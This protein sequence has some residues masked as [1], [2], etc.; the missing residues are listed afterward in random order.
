MSATCVILAF[1]LRTLEHGKA[2]RGSFDFTIAV[3]SPCLADLLLCQRV[4]GVNLRSRLVSNAA[5]GHRQ[6]G[7]FP[8]GTA[9][10]L[11]GRHVP[12]KPDV[13]AAPS[14]TL[15][16][17]AGMCIVGSRNRVDGGPDIAGLAGG[18]HPLFPAGRQ[19]VGGDS[20]ARLF[21][22][23]I[24]VAAYRVHGCNPAGHGAMGSNHAPGRVLARFILWLQSGGSGGGL[25]AGRI[26][27][28][29]GV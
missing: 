18:R 21:Y 10:H 6:F 13:V 11:Y 5:T 1:F 25:P 23:G 19:R 27:F 16:P 26:L 24:P 14:S 20:F 8:G 4:C 17:P 29:T 28:V 3:V 9:G 22:G 15:E 7:G 2:E 12:R